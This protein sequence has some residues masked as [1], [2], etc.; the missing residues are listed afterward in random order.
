MGAPNSLSRLFEHPLQ[1]LGSSLSLCACACGKLDSVL[2]SRGGAACNAECAVLV[3]LCCMSECFRCWGAAV[4][5]PCCLSGKLQNLN[6]A[7]NPLSDPIPSQHWGLDG[8]SD[9]EWPEGHWEGSV[10]ADSPEW[11]RPDRQHP[12]PAGCIS[13]VADPGFEQQQPYRAGPCRAGVTPKF[14]SAAVVR[15]QAQRLSRRVS[16]L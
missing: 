13:S 9:A 16:A 8:T 5:L 15:Q 1:V 12:Q 2:G 7:H 11:R 10:V 4:T 6:L 3:Q 14:A